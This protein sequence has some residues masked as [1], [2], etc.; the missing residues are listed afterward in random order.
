MVRDEGRLASDEGAEDEDE[1]ELVL[2]TFFMAVG[3]RVVFTRALPGIQ[4]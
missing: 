1:E 3:H 4:T 2:L